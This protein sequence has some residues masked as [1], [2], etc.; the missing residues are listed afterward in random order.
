MMGFA[1]LNPSYWLT[2]VSQ[3][4]QPPFQYCLWLCLSDRFRDAKSNVIAA[5]ISDCLHR[6]FVRTGDGYPTNS[7]C[8]YADKHR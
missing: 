5:A 8:E 2:K 3:A 1:A 4:Q 7:N 6:L